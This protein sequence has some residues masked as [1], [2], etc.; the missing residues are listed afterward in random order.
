MVT[1]VFFRETYLE[2]E[3]GKGEKRRRLEDRKGHTIVKEDLKA[4]TITIAKMRRNRLIKRRQNLKLFENM[5]G[6]T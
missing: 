5:F 4:E 3:Q 1:E 6:G 2:Y